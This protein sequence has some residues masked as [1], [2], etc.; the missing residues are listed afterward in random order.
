MVMDKDSIEDILWKFEDYLGAYF[1]YE[2]ARRG[3]SGARLSHAG[4][5]LSI[6]RAF[7]AEFLSDLIIGQS[8]PPATPPQSGE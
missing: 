6:G 5:R 1:D 8:Q 3:L 7:F 4:E 2:A